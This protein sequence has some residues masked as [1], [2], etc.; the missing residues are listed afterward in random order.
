MNQDFIQYLCSLAPEGE[1]A[2]F[3]QQKPTKGGT[4][5]HADGAIKCTWLA[6]FP[7]KKR[8]ECL[9]W[10]CN[11]GS[12]I[13][14]RL[15]KEKPSA[16]SANVEYVLCLILDDVGTKSKEPPLE[17]TWSIETS[18]N[19]YQYGY[20]FSEQP[21]K[22]AYSAAIKAIAAAGY[23]DAGATNAVR[24]FRIPGSVNIKPGKQEY[25]SK[26]LAFHPDNEYTLDE[27]LE[28]LDVKPEAE[29]NNRLIPLR[30]DA[31]L[32]ADPVVQW[33]AENILALSPPN[34]EGWMWI[35]CP[36]HAEH[37]DGNETARYMPQD[38]AFCCYHAH[39]Q[40]FTSATFLEWVAEN[41]GPVAA[42]GIREDLLGPTLKLALDKLEPSDLYRKDA[43]KITEELA[44]K[45]IGRLE[46]SEWYERFA[47]LQDD[48]AFFDLQERRVVTRAAFNAL[49]RHISCKSIHSKRK[50]EASVCYDENR[51]AH[52]AKTLNGIT[53][54]A[55]DNV[56]VVRD[57]DTFGNRWK[58]ARPEVDQSR[59]SSADRWLDHG[60]RLI[61]DEQELQ[62]VLNVMAYKLQHPRGKINH[63]V[64]H[65]GKE[66][67]GKDTFWAPFLWSVCGPHLRNRGYMDS[68]TMNQNWNDYVESEIVLINELKEPEAA[69]RRALANKLKP[70]I[71]APP[72]MLDVHRRYLHPYKT[73]NRV[74][75]LAF[76]NDQVPISLAS[77]DR[78]WFCIWSG[79]GRMDSE[80]AQSLWNWYNDGGFEEIAAWLYQRDV[81]LFNPMAAPFDTE[82]KQNLI[83]NGMSMAESY[84]V[85]MIQG[86][87]GEFAHGIIG[88]PFSGLCD[89]LAGLAPQGVKIV[90]GALLHAFQE[91][92]WLDKG[93]LKSATNMNPKHIF[94]EPSVVRGWSKTDMRDKVE[95][96][97]KES[98]LTTHLRR[99]K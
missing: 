58:N 12:F 20:T 64:L 32:T 47:Y 16:S 74:F 6:Q 43:D 41:G 50:I 55:G 80:E 2:L 25:E 39:C 77:Q 67:C 73:A 62:H 86:R 71:A 52:R 7:S 13:L 15:D 34:S 95:E 46:K 44:H 31:G 4:E 51:K 69:T 93:R 53:Y 70:I 3:V 72:T 79:A 5:R 40:D 88:G 27:I 1:T 37:T 81:S 45:E 42:P 94:A 17:P 75:V 8:K 30:L 89:R 29:S 35:V 33:L 76:S 85:E 91:A 97:Q 9:A 48:E 14:D 66:G 59:A 26:I 82:F 61:P 10:Y 49:F 65:A 38:R 84:L 90:K 96:I 24:N 87:E 99:A 19:N 18:Q 78:R 36:N 68:D 21:T 60:R 11:T 57:G 83:E 56:I 63:A 92:G 28:A 22:A 98:I 23:T 54:A